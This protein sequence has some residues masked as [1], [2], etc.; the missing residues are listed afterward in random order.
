MLYL[1]KNQKDLIEIKPQAKK[2]CGYIQ[3]GYY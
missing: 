3:I 1:Q 2:T